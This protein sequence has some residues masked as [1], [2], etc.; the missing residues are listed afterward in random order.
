MKKIEQ[1]RTD[2]ITED[3]ITCIKNDTISIHT[4]DVQQSR[5]KTQNP[6]LQN[7]QP[8]KKIQT[9]KDDKK[10]VDIASLIKGS[11]NDEKNKKKIKTDGRNSI[12]L[13]NGINKYTNFTNDW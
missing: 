9:K 11:Q 3:K 7:L 13:N 8:T 6:F 2:V 4:N 1:K 10:K 12:K 5:I